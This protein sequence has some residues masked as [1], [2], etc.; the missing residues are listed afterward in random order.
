MFTM[1][2]K[3]EK[4]F[5]LTGI[6]GPFKHQS[7]T[8]VQTEYHLN[9]KETTTGQKV[10]VILVLGKDSIEALNQDREVIEEPH[11]VEGLIARLF[12]E[13]LRKDVTISYSGGSRG[14]VDTAL[15]LLEISGFT[16]L[17]PVA[18]EVIDT[19]IRRHP[20]LT[21]PQT[22]PQGEKCSPST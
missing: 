5:E 2:L 10:G 4:E 8:S 6:E 7:P 20:L 15:T 14:Q 19:L 1:K 9:V 11:S 17:S 16:F 18:V 21:Y 3:V 12:I 13:Q 22:Y